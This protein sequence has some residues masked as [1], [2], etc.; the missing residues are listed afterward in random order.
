MVRRAAP[1]CAAVQ[2]WHSRSLRAE[3]ILEATA[4]SDP[5]SWRNQA[6]SQ[7]CAFSSPKKEADERNRDFS[8]TDMQAYFLGF[9]SVFSREMKRVFL[10]HRQP[11]GG[12]L[13]S[14]GNA[15][16]AFGNLM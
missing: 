16:I 3:S 7:A 1:R 8:P 13:S 15:G 9:A 2:N 4:I 6:F 12:L 14:G 5:E 11:N 10:T